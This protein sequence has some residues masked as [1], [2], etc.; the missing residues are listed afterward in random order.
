MHIK[1]FNYLICH[2]GKEKGETVN[3]RKPVIVNLPVE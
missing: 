1:Y 3:A 2:A